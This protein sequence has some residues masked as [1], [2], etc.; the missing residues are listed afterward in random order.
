[1]ETPKCTAVEFSVTMKFEII[2]VLIWVMTVLLSSVDLI[3]VGAG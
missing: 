3:P 2:N 1:M